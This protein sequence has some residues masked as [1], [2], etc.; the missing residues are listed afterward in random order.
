SLITF[1]SLKSAGRLG[2]GENVVVQHLFQDTG[3]VLGHQVSGAFGVTERPAE[4]WAEQFFQAEAMNLKLGAG[5][6]LASHLSPSLTALERGADLS[7]RSMET[8]PLLPEG[9]NQAWA[10]AGG[11]FSGLSPKE[12]KNQ[13]LFKMKSFSHEA[14]ER[15]PNAENFPSSFTE[16]N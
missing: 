9:V 10:M 4:S 12:G 15:D 1:G 13:N 8:P 6:A 7:I 11:P 3:L 16:G 2:Q 14:S 5:M